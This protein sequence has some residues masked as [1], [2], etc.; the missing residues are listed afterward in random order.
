MTLRE[1]GAGIKGWFS[2]SFEALTTKDRVDWPISLLLIVITFV[3]VASLVFVDW[4]GFWR[5]QVRREKEWLAQIP[6]G[7]VEKLEW[8]NRTGRFAP[9]SSRR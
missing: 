7:P 5:A 9:K 6:N 4:S 8:A 3:F 1:F 2:T